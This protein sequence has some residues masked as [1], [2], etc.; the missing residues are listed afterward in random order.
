MENNIELSAHIRKIEI[1][2]KR[3]LSGTL[4]GDKRSA[5]KG[6]GYDFDQIREYRQGDDVRFIAWNALAKTGT[7]LLKEYTEERNRSIVVCLDISAS[8]IY[9][10]ST[11][12]KSMIMNDIATV[13][14][15]VAGYGNDK[16]GLVFFSDTVE[17]VIPAGKGRHHMQKVIREIIGHT[18]KAGAINI[19]ALLSYLV[20]N[21][22]K[23]SLFVIISDFIDEGYEKLAG[24]IARRCEIVAIRCLDRYESSLP[25]V[26]LGVVEDIETGE[27]MILNMS[28]HDLN[29]FLHDREVKQKQLLQSAGID[30]L[31]VDT[32]PNFIP[33][34]IVFF[35]KRMNY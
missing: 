9:A 22:N 21:K 5:L 28:A 27:R 25:Q 3:L 20:Q 31:T 24:A 19:Q 26:G 13:I 1:Y 23:N 12:A 18:S 11:H 2:I 8:R 29:T 35:K 32:S 33:K 7:L 30:M 14:A 17:C 6:S 16:I 15:L 4:V 34:L 10:S